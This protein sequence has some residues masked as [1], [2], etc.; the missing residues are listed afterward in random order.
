MKKRKKSLIK[1]L[2]E[3]LSNFKDAVKENIRLNLSEFIKNLMNN[4]I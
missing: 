4:I 1:E 2:L 3:I